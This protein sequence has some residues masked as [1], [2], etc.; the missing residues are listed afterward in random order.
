MMRVPVNGGLPKL[1]F[2]TK[3]ALWENHQCARAP[4]SLCVVIESSLDQKRLT[5]TAL[6]PL[7]GKGKLLRT[8][9][10]DHDEGL[11]HDLS[12]DG[13]TLAISRGNQPEIR[14]RLL[15]LTGGEDREIAVKG[16]PNPESMEWAADGKGFYCGSASSSGLTLLYLDLKGTAQVLW[17]SGQPGAGPFVWC[18]TFTGWPPPCAFRSR[19]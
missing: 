12:P 11:N 2:E 14:I 9:E 8:I 1:V 17:Q 3:G 15:S 7:Q 19:V 18:H 4:A 13:S 16:W 5:V 10:K 6:D